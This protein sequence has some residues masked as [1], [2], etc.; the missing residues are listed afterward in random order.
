MRKGQEGRWNGE[1][2]DKLEEDEEGP[3]GGLHPILDSTTGRTQAADQLQMENEE[4]RKKTMGTRN[5]EWRRKEKHG[6]AN[7]FASS[8][9]DQRVIRKLHT[10]K[11]YSPHK[12]GEDQV[13]SEAR[14]NTSGAGDA[15]HRRAPRP[16]LAG[17][18]NIAVSGAGTGGR[19]AQARLGARERGV[20]QAVRGVGELQRTNWGERLREYAL[21][22][23]RLIEETLSFDGVGTIHG[24]EKSCSASAVDVFAKFSPPIPSPRRLFRRL[25]SAIFRSSSAVDPSTTGSSD[26]DDGQDGDDV[27]CKMREVGDVIA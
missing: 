14:E 24:R 9:L 25:L 8:G 17:S 22:S 6:K 7:S 23:A 13:H 16:R 21:M 4:E 5:Q 3:D 20:V 2:E 10:H 15:R 11:A 26:A 12:R 27:G 1:D 18:E 19:E